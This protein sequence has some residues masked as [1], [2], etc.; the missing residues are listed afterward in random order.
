VLWRIAANPLKQER[1]RK[2]GVKGKHLK[3][4]RNP[5]YFSEELSV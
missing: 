2:H 3:V 5:D 4:A 1:A